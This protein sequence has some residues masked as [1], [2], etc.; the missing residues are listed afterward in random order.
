MSTNVSFPSCLL[1]FESVLSVTLINNAE[2]LLRTLQRS[3]KI[4]LNM[5]QLMLKLWLSTEKKIYYM[6]QEPNDKMHFYHY[7]HTNTHTSY[8]HMVN[9]SH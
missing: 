9:T 3:K 4:L 6:I 7:Y 2:A 1:R 5:V 8:T